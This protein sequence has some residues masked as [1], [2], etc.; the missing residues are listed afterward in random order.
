M[1]AIVTRLFA[2]ELDKNSGPLRVA[3]QARLRYIANYSTNRERD[4]TWYI[5]D[6]QKLA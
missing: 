1:T 2:L 5:A 6:I 3:S 4:A